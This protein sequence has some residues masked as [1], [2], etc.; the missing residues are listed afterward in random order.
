MLYNLVWQATYR[1]DRK[2]GTSECVY[3]GSGKVPLLC[4]SCAFIVL[5]IA[6]VMEH[7]YM[8]IAISKSST[9]VSWEP[10]SSSARSI[11]WQAGFLFISTW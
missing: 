7:A 4:C 8:L 9:L 3:S 10:D 11:A 6:M 5:A 1:G 2:E